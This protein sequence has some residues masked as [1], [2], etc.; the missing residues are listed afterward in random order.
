MNFEEH[1]CMDNDLDEWIITPRSRFA[2][3]TILAGEEADRYKFTF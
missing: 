1:R 2:K 3:D